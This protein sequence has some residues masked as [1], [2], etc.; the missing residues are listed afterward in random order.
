MKPDARTCFI[1]P[2]VPTLQGWQGH[3]SILPWFYFRSGEGSALKEQGSPSN[4][5]TSRGS[6]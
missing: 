1:E 6:K 2:N 3:Q 5:I 4:A